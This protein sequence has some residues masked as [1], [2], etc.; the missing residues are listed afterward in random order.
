[1]S[2]SNKSTQSNF[3]RGSDT[4]FHRA[5]MLMTNVL[6]N[7]LLFAVFFICV[8]W[9]LFC[10]FS[11][12]KDRDIL[13]QNRQAVIVEVI[14]LA[15]YFPL[16]LDIKT[17]A[18]K[19]QRE[20][21]AAADVVAAT[22]E[23]Y[24]R[25]VSPQVVKTMGIAFAVTAVLL[26][27]LVSYQFRRGQKL[28]QDEYLRGAVLVDAQTLKQMV[29]DPS[30]FLIGEVPLEADKIKRNILM[31]GAMG[32]GKSQAILQL[33]DTAR[34]QGKKC[35]IYDKTGEF[36]EYFYREGKDFILNPLDARC[37]PWTAFNDLRKDFDFSTLSTFFVPE[38]KKS[39]DPV[40]DNA[41]R[42]LLEDVFRIVFSMPEHRQNMQA[43]QDIIVRT[44][45][46]K[47]AKLLVNHGATSA[48][49]INE[50]ND[51]GSESIRLTLAASPAIKYF[52]YLPLPVPGETRFS[53]RDWAQTDGDSWLFLTSRADQHEAL[54]P[55]VSL[56][57]ELSIMAVM[58]LR[59]TSDLR[60]LLFLDELAS[61]A[62]MRG[63]EIALTEAR[64]YGVATV[65]GLQSLSQLDAVY[66]PD[67]SKVLAGNCQNKLILRVEDES[68]TKRYADLLGKEEIQ[69]VR[70]GV[71][72]GVE[73]ERDGTNL[74]SQRGEKYIV[75][76]AEIGRLPD[77]AGYLKL[78]GEYPVAR[79]DVPYKQRSKI[80]GDFVERDGLDVVR[81]RATEEHHD[82]FE[83]DAAVPGDEPTEQ[84]T[85]EPEDRDIDVPDI[86]SIINQDKKPE[87]FWA[88]SEA[89][90]PS[91]EQE[92]EP[93]DTHPYLQKPKSHSLF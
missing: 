28:A 61:L 39:A 80:A 36:A 43:V 6:R 44:S 33:M 89:A 79:V 10:T 86:E 1:M 85:E 75:M 78:A 48:A 4:F 62:R 90:E 14:G 25:A 16:S 45:L 38:N 92:I 54:K 55:F 72:F 73:T 93:P 52:S 32:T 74:S 58:T 42:I 47:L 69:E 21:F 26:F 51:R 88:D 37:A 22:N 40:W 18:G 15:D 11:T 81:G 19:I 53:I 76:P 30:E 24:R 56:W 63:L 50:K 77:L 66:G 82:E 59:P 2:V 35:I 20:E 49:T 83:E 23:Y 60:F 9:G 67:W 7:I 17:A 64:K 12:E 34:A 8:W 31:T 68:T 87:N 13:I 91:L 29:K 41:A 27:F 57:V 5:Q 65:I 84:S 71:S 70:E 46:G 3:I